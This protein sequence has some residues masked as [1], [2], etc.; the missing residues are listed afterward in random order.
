MLAAVSPQ[1]AQGDAGFAAWNKLASLAKKAELAPIAQGT[2]TAALQDVAAIQSYIQ[3]VSKLAAR[4]I[5]ERNAMQ[6]VYANAQ[7]C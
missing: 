1:I 5:A 4:S 3:E 2:E 7:G 6:R